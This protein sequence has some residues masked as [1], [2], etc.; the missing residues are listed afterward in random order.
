MFNDHNTHY[1]TISTNSNTYD[2]A[3]KRNTNDIHIKILRCI[4]YKHTTSHSIIQ[5]SVIRIL[6]TSGSRRRCTT[7]LSASEAS[8][9][10]YYDYD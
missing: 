3:I 6:L 1:H 4:N 5:L 2:H 7:A 10:P 9:R 8:R